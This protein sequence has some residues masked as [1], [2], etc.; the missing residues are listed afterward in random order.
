MRA[1]FQ[2]RA[3]ASSPKGQHAGNPDHGNHQGEG[4]EAAEHDGSHTVVRQ[5]FG[6]NI[7]QRARVLYGRVAAAARMVFVMV[8]TSAYGSFFARTIRLAPNR[9]TC[10][11]G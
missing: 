3:Y 10:A 4:G 2:T 5:D 1:G 8:G 9:G 7:F 11:K 6:A